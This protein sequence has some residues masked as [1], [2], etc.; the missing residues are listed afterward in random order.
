MINIILILGLLSVLGGF[1]L[2]KYYR[3]KKAG[4]DELRAD[5]A[6]KTLNQIS[7]GKDAVNRLDDSIINQLRKR[8]NIE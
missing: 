3:D 1:G 7:K 6:E 2:F 5:N 4:R 8:Y